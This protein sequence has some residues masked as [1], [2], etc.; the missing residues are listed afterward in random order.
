M[1]ASPLLYKSLYTSGASPVSELACVDA[2][3]PYMD[4]RYLPSMHGTDIKLRPRVRLRN[5]QWDLLTRA[6]GID[7]DTE[8]GRLLNFS[9]SSLWRIKAGEVEPTGRFIAAAIYHFGGRFEELF[10]ITLEA[11]S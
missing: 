6:K 2:L 8:C 4:M 11:E 3:H 5:A 1:D 7:G 10:E 9:Q